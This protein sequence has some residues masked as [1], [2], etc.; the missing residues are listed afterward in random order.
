MGA[1]APAF[2]LVNAVDGKTV[3]MKPDDGGI[4]VVVFTCNH[5]R[6]RRRSSRGSS[7]SPNKFAQ[8]GVKFYAV[9]P[10]DDAQYA[11]ET[12]R[13][14]EGA[15][16]GPEHTASRTSRTATAASPAR[17]ALASRRTCSWSTAGAS[18]AIAATW[19]IPRKPEE[20]KTTGLTD[21]LNALINGREVQT[22]TRARSGARSSGR[23]ESFARY[24]ARFRGP[25][26]PT[27]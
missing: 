7:R 2:S 3:T 27:G 23:G 4:K 16:G 19:T 14:H 20:R 24:A 22:R 13:E 9:N 5:A 6:S 25:H 1:K 17:T 11:E 10:N 8:K 26:V 21:A 12:L 15:R 18:S